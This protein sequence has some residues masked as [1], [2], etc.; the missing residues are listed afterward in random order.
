LAR[1]VGQLHPD[2]LEAAVVYMIPAATLEPFVSKEHRDDCEKIL[3][4]QFLLDGSTPILLI[5]KDVTIES[6]LVELRRF[7][8]MTLW[9]TSYIE[10]YYKN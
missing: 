10:V 6:Y 1:L 4:A 8:D 2:T 9:L 7:I 3:I 5:G